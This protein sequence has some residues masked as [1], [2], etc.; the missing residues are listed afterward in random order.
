MTLNDADEASSAQTHTGPMRGIRIVDFSIALTGPYAAA[1]L[2]DQGASVVKIERPGIGD[3]A[4]WVGVA[5]NGISALYQ[6][7]NRGKR[8]ISIDL[9]S[10]RG[11]DHARNPG[12]SRSTAC[13]GCR[14]GRGPRSRLPRHRPTGRCSRFRAVRS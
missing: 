6:S 11:R 3:I 10:E 5:V 9:D 1:L 12:R 13:L 14:I 8:S 7:C 2:A 4:R